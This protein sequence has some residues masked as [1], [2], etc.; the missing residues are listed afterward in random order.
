LVK[1]GF[2]FA[3]AVTMLSIV[4]LVDRDAFAQDSDI[5]GYGDSAPTYSDYPEYGDVGGNEIHGQG[6]DPGDVHGHIPDSSRL[7]DEAAHGPIHTAEPMPRRPFKL[8]DVVIPESD[9][10]DVVSQDDIFKA[11]AGTAVRFSQ[12]SQGEYG[13]GRSEG[14]G[15]RTVTGVFSVRNKYRRTFDIAGQAG[16]YVASPE[17]NLYRLDK[18][19]VTITFDERGEIS[20]ITPAVPVQ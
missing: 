16:V 12:P 18:Q 1:T 13:V 10:D 6:T 19:Q 5:Y 7:G 11:D 17:E 15:P 3:L 8:P 9:Y 4:A 2:L 14:G 20:N